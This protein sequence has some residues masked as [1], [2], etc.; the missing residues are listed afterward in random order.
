MIKIIITNKIEIQNFSLL[1]DFLRQ[2]IISRHEFTNPAY[3]EA[4]KRGRF[5]GNMEQILKF[6]SCSNDSL[7][8]P[9]GSAR[10]L[11]LS[12][13]KHG[14]LFDMDDRRRELDSVEFQFMSTLRPYQQAATEAVLLRQ[15]GVLVA[16]TGS[17]KTTMA[18]YIAAMRRQST[19][20]ITHSKEIAE[21]WL[22]RIVQF[23]GIPKEEVGMI[24]NSKFRIGK[25]ITVALVQSLIKRADEVVP[26]IGFVII[27]ECHRTASKTF[28]KAV[29]NF[30][31]K[32]ILGLSATPFRRDKLT[33][34][35]WFFLGDKIHEVDGTSLKNEGHVMRPEIIIR[36]INIPGFHSEYDPV[37]KYSSFLTDL[38]QGAERTAKICDDIV[39]A[40]NEGRYSII[41]SDRINQLDSIESMLAEKNIKSAKLTGS[42]TKK[43]RAASMEEIKARKVNVLLAS[44]SLAAEGLDIPHLD[45]LFIVS[46]I[47]FEG[48]MVQVAGRVLRP[49]EGK[50]QPKLFDYIDTGFGVLRS[51]AAS[52]Q[53]VYENLAA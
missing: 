36:E 20:V 10:Q 29:Q 37:N 46:P 15:Q 18:L 39:G 7:F 43:A 24:G 13:N 38:L 52:R 42:M 23:M 19:I 47:K 11:V 32:Y 41:L 45:A 40:V 5:T 51:Q 2:E 16:P 28:T 49:L 1:P 22:E 27:D 44:S 33:R 17:G 50:R 12:L 21:Q 26:Y 31:A 8:L 9:R 14:I 6:W 34:L 53:K 4:R 30:D 3:E 35:L 48:K 25:K